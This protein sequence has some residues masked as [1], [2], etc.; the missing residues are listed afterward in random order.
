MANSSERRDFGCQVVIDVVLKVEDSPEVYIHGT[1]SGLRDLAG[2]LVELAETDQ[3]TE[4]YMRT[5][6]DHHHCRFD[7]EPFVGK[8]FPLTISR[9]DDPRPDGITDQVLER[10]DNYRL[11]LVDLLKRT[12]ADR[13]KNN[14]FVGSID[15]E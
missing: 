6:P 5:G 2:L 15:D 14:E 3:E 4:F 8:G 9:L 13:I 7:Q 1:P 12:R 10:A 11:I